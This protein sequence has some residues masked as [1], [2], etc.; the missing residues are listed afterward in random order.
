MNKNFIEKMSKIVFTVLCSM[1]L[2]S[3]C[4]KP[5][6]RPVDRTVNGVYSGITFGIDS[7]VKRLEK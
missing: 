2:F 1:L 4:Y 6:P 5:N 3:A 7:A